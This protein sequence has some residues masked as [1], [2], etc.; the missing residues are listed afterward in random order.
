MRQSE[1]HFKAEKEFP[2][3][4]VSINARFLIRANFIN[5]LMAGVYSFM[6]LGLMVRE[7]IISI[8]RE[9]MNALH[10]N[11][12]LMPALH[13]RS[14]W[15]ATKRWEGGLSEIMYQFKDHSGKEVGLGPTHEEVIAP[16][17][18]TV[19][20]S[21][22]D[23]PLGMYQ[24]QTKFRDEP[25]VKSG[26]LR[27]R[28]FLMK[29]LYSFHTDK[30]SLDEYYEE[31]KKAYKKIF[32]RC[33]LKSYVTEA[34]GGDFSK[35]YSHEFMVEAEAGEDEINLCRLCGYAKNKEIAEEKSGASCPKCKTG[36]LEKVKTVEAGNIFKLGTR[37]SEAAGLFYK[38]KN[39]AMEPVIMAS[40]GIGIDRL[41]G[42]IAE[43]YHD[44]NGVIWP[45]SVAPF[46]VHLLLI[47]EVTDSLQKFGNQVYNKLTREGLNLL[48][49]DRNN[50]SA[51]EKFFE[52]DLIGI[53]WRL[54]ISDKTLIHN[55]IEI[56]K[57]NEKETKL[58][59]IEEL[60]NIL[61]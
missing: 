23:L 38:N 53:P 28:E 44:E 24:F 39:G 2:K 13:P 48:Y 31:V 36:I 61:K 12:I 5:K 22:Q 51:G 35:E 9:E 21:Y 37:F 43:I 20:E 50:V 47:G 17:A 42:T 1:L 11:E 46:N 3:D 29:D 10:A 27:G 34:S 52:A 58:L 16:L 25:R 30:A 8:V 60:L 57:R 55:K 45:E 18:K 40:Y 6:P 56:K 54:V 32:E 19:I 4:E 41:M 59:K 15:D 14:V 49:D 7:K 26:L 33:G